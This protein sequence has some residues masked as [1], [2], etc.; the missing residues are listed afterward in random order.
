MLVTQ[1]R[2]RKVA[3]YFSCFWRTKSS[4]V[5]RTDPGGSR[6]TQDKEGLRKLK[7]QSDQN[8]FGPGPERRSCRPD[9]NSVN[10]SSI[11]ARMRENEPV[12]FM[13]KVG[14]WARFKCPT[15]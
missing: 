14:M 15:I 13:V 1:A 9:C 8:S 3:D 2:Y 11:R 6:D 5:G 7:N 4:S 12:K 10:G